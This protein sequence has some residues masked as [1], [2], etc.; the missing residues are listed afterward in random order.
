TRNGPARLVL[1]S[2]DG[3]LDPTELD[4]ETLADRLEASDLTANPGRALGRALREPSEESRDVILLTHP[5]ALREPA[6]VAAA[7]DRRS[8]DRILALSVEES[9]RAELCELADPEPAT[10]LAFRVDLA[11]AEAA[12]IDAA[13]TRTIAEGDRSAWTGDVEPVPFPFRPG[14]ITE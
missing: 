3:A 4:S 7:K 10:I 9:G 2:M 6:V 8:G 1:T 14:L 13:P 5:R 11:G 12:R